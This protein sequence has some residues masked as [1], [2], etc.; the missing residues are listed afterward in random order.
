[1]ALTVEHYIHISQFGNT[2]VDLNN[3][4]LIP[5]RVKIQHPTKDQ[6]QIVQTELMWSQLPNMSEG[7]IRKR[8]IRILQIPS[9]KI[10]SVVTLWPEIS[11]ADAP[12]SWN[13][14]HRPLSVKDADPFRLVVEI[15]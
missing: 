8:K 14:E 11:C 7:L 6:S 15:L 12:Q 4:K 13:I 1:M 9:H 10:T 2:L 5:V 3:S